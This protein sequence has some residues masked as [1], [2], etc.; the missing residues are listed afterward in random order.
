MLRSQRG[1][2]SYW[3][4]FVLPALLMQ[5][6]QRVHPLSVRRLIV[7]VAMDAGY[8]LVELF[9]GMTNPGE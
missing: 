2:F 4:R 6:R 9:V 3:R 8:D 7:D 5:E 1:T